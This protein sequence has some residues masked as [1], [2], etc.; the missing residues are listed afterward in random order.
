MILFCAGD[1]S[2]GQYNKK[3]VEIGINFFWLLKQNVRLFNG[4]STLEAHIQL[5]VKQMKKQP[6]I[7][8]LWF[9]L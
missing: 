2:R 1:M 5:V 9:Y 4:A 7:P 3:L 8:Y 6:E